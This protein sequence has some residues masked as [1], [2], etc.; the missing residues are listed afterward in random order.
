MTTK[1]SYATAFLLGLGMIFLGS[2][3]FWSPQAATAGYGIQFD[4]H[5]DYSFH[6]IKG[7]RDLFSG[8]I[9]CVFVLLDER[10][11]LGLTLLAGTMIPLTDMLIV[12]SK[13]YHTVLQALPHITAIA[14]CAVSGII[15]LAAKTQS[16]TR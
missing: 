11:A 8:L 13:S 10:R 5:G 2:R 15:L 12:L 1:I 7:I 6:Y 3:F 9:I 16:K 14:I 4:A